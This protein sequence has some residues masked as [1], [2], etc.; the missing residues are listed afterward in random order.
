MKSFYTAR[1]YA[2]MIHLG[3]AHYTKNP[4][5][6]LIQ[7]TNEEIRI[8]ETIIPAITKEIYLLLTPKEKTNE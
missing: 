5:K 7:N 2:E 3:G 4:C 6:D 8:N 1:N